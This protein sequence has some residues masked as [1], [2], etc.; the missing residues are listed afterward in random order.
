MWDLCHT[1]VI[2]MLKICHPYVDLVQ[3]SE[4][5]CA[6]VIPMSD[7]CHAYVIPML[8]IFHPYVDLVPLSEPCWTYVIPMLDLCRR[9]PIPMSISA[10]YARPLL[11]IFHTYVD[12]VPKCHTWIRKILD[13][14]LGLGLGLWVGVLCSC[15]KFLDL[16]FAV[17]IFGFYA[18]FCI[19]RTPRWKK[20]KFED[21]LRPPCSPLSKSLVV[22]TSENFFSDSHLDF[23]PMMQFSVANSAVKTRIKIFENKNRNSRFEWPSVQSK[24]C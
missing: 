23:G 17:A 8:K 20:W 18:E 22:K 12:L 21:F 11:E 4:P 15:Q 9:C 2:P 10:T 24:S 19:E 6:S 7:L 3:M 14:I 13:L 16:D 5:C 1:Y